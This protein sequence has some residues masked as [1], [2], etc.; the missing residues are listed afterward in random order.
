MTAP[1][2]PEPFGVELRDVTLSFGK[3]EKHPAL[4]GLSLQVRP[5]T[6]TGLLGRNGAGKT[7]ALSLIAAMRRPD[8]GT[9]LVDGEDPFENAW[10]MAGTQLVRES[11]DTIAATKVADSL[12]YYAELR[13]HWDADLAAGLVDLFEIDLRK[14]PESLSRG[15]RSALGA[16]I[17]LASRAPLTIFD[18]VYLG[19]DAPS[20]YAFYDA[21]VEDYTEHPRTIV[22]SSHLIDEVERIFEDV[23]IMDEGRVLLAESAESVRARGVSLTGTAAVVEQFVDGRR[24]LARQRLGSTAQVT[25]FGTLDDAERAAATEAGLEL[26]AVPLQDLF[27]HLTREERS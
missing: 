14:A 26:G 10:A 19:M 4:D 25:L 9:V 5:G 18:E 8:A 20:R 21:L 12:G 1:T 23:V 16:V 24:V 11:G 22:L 17:G 6:I 15:K 27:V 2:R 3:D 7:T 13:E